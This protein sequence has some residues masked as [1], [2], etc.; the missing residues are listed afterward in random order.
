[1]HNI[2]HMYVYL[3]TRAKGVRVSRRHL[4]NFSFDCLVLLCA[5]IRNDVY[6]KVS[7]PGHGYR[8]DETSNVTVE[9]HKSADVCLLYS[10]LASLIPPVPDLHPSGDFR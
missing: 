5:V 8:E 4:H 9:V 7:A 6:L 1:M 2:Y 3:M 10:T